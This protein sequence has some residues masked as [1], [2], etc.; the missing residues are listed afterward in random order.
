MGR[1]S[2]AYSVSWPLYSQPLRR[3]DRP[4]ASDR[5][6]RRACLSLESLRAC[7][8]ARAAWYWRGCLWRIAQEADPLPSVAS[9]SAELL[10]LAH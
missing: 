8:P 7:L 5:P 10:G 9:R 4:A 3:P 1:A 6:A 2:A